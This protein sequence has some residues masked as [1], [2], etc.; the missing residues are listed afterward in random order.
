M[1]FRG[2]SLVALIKNR[3]AVCHADDE[4][5][6]MLYSPKVTGCKMPSSSKTCYG[7]PD[8]CHTVIAQQLG[9]IIKGDLFRF[10]RLFLRRLPNILTS[11]FRLVFFHNAP[12]DCFNGIGVDRWLLGNIGRF[13]AVDIVQDRVHKKLR[14]PAALQVEYFCNLLMLWVSAAELDGEFINIFLRH[15]HH[16]IQAALNNSS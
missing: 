12:H 14:F 5:I 6:F 15:S 9:S 13:G 4:P 16:P 8:G 2:Y 3:F 11:G 10:N 7:V 1:S